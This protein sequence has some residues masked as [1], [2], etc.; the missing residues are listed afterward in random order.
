MTKTLAIIGNN[1]TAVMYFG[2]EEPKETIMTAYQIA[3]AALIDLPIGSIIKVAA[4]TG[5]RNFYF[6]HSDSGI[7]GISPGA[8]S[9]ALD[10]CPVEVR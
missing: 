1:D 6:Q 9:R 5:S 8:Y 2:R 10:S 7:V 4:A 3:E